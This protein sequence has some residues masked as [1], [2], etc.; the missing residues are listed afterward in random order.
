M[1]KTSLS[2][3]ENSEI[4]ELRSVVTAM[5]AKIIVDFAEP[6]LFTTLTI[7]SVVKKA[8]INEAK[9]KSIKYDGK[10][11]NSKMQKK[12]PPEFTPIILGEASSLSVTL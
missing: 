7:K 8:P 5:P 9:G 2:I 1:L 10:S 12:P 6:I 11:V 4:A 3:S